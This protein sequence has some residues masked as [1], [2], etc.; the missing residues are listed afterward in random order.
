MSERAPR[1]PHA[2]LLGLTLLLCSPLAWSRVSATQGLWG[3]LVAASLSVGI[4]ALWISLRRQRVGEP[5]GLVWAPRR[6]H[7]VQCLA[8]G[9]VYVGWCS[10]WEVAARHLQLLAAQV[11]FAY[12]V[13][14]LSIWRRRPVYRLGFGPVPIVMSTNLFLF[15]KD[16]HFYWQWP[17]IALALLSRELFRWRREG[18]ERHIFNPSAIALSLTALALIGTESMDRSWGE[19]IALSHATAPW[20]YELMFGAGLLVMGLFGVGPTIISAALT[21][22]ALGALFYQY[23]GTYRYLDTAIPAAVFLGM[24]LLVTDPATSPKSA[25]GKSIYGALYGV[26]VFALYGLLRGLERPPIGDEPGLSAAF[27]DKLLAVPLLNVLSPLIERAAEWMRSCVM[28][29]SPA[30]VE[31]LLLRR[32]GP[33]FDGGVRLSLVALWSLCF[34][35]WVRPQLREHPGRSLSVWLKACDETAAPQREPFACANRDRIYRQLCERGELGSCHNLAVSWEHGEGGFVDSS[36]AASLYQRACD[37]G[38][39]MSC[40]HLGGLYVMEAERREDGSWARRAEPLL[41]RACDGQLWPACARLAA[42]KLSPWVEA[43]DFDE[44]W[45]LWEDACHHHEP[46]SCFELGQRSLIPLPVRAQRCMA[47]D[48]LACLSAQR[49]QRQPGAALAQARDELMSACRG[50][51][52]VACAN[53]AWMMWRGDGGPK[54]P[55][56]GLELMKRSCEGGLAAACDRLKAMSAER[57]RP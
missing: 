32:R 28:G 14:M 3:G 1:A 11:A 17:M 34:V 37:G 10:H 7:F 27:C 36:Q 13:D 12:L 4:A 24:N 38:R 49:S 53:V 19:A 42:L 2:L 15:F 47:G 39:L 21:T 5:W 54:S 44:A 26:S 50:E 46:F 9:L 40:H 51:L 33:W 18:V 55:E 45:A 52:W 6:E 31:A 25:L 29:W 56:Q 16:E 43:P 35:A 30:R 48:Q 20:S 22:I 8:Q 57:A 41:R 23:T